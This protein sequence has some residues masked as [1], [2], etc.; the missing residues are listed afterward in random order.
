MLFNKHKESS[1]NKQSHKDKHQNYYCVGYSVL[2]YQ[3]D[4]EEIGNLIDQQGEEAS[5]EII[6]TFLPRVVVESLIAALHRADLKWR[7]LPLSRL[8]LLMS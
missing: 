5:V 6:A 4:D 1:L 8:P 2:N 7:P 3:L